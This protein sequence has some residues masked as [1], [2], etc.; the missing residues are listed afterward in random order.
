MVLSDTDPNPVVF[1]TGGL[2]RR[3]FHLG[4]LRDRAGARPPSAATDIEAKAK[5]RSGSIYGTNK[6]RP[7]W[8]LRPLAVLPLSPAVLNAYK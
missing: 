3:V 4:V 1:A 5:P 8:G 2:A 6:N 7:G